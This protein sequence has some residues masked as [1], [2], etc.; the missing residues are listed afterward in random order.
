M[1]VGCYTQ[2]ELRERFLFSLAV[3]IQCLLLTV[4]GLDYPGLLMFSSVFGVKGWKLALGI[5]YVH[6]LFV[7][8]GFRAIIST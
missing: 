1:F 7:F 4:P 6:R 5:G 3:V 8:Y 2:G